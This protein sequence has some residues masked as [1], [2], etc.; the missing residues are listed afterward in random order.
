MATQRA[1]LRFYD[2]GFINIGQIV[3]RELYIDHAT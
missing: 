2:H 3:A 1:Q